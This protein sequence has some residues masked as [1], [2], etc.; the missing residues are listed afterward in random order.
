M[1]PVTYQVFLLCAVEGA[2]IPAQGQ[3]SSVIPTGSSRSPDGHV[4][5]VLAPQSRNQVR[6][7]W[8]WKLW[9]KDE[10]RSIHHWKVLAG[11]PWLVPGLWKVN[12]SNGTNSMTTGELRRARG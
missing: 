12:V 9:R 5:G 1:A 8:L 2:Q 7:S 11:L 3:L 4:L 10:L 6:E